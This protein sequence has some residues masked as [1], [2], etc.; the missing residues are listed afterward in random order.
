MQVWLPCR[1]RR[2]YFINFYPIL[3]HYLK[4]Q[5]NKQILNDCVILYWEFDMLS[6][7]LF[8]FYEFFLI[9]FD[10]RWALGLKE[11][12]K[13]TDNKFIIVDSLV[14]VF[15][16]RLLFQVAGSHV[17][18]YEAYYQQVI[19]SIMYAGPCRLSTDFSFR[20]LSLNERDRF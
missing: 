12:E 13:A 7:W 17:A 10:N 1:H 15:S 6:H 2:R 14:T 18:I 5:L 16:I 4:L 9:T 8:S 19:I 20:L 11:A 3:R